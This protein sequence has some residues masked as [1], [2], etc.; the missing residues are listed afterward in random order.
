MLTFASIGGGR[1]G[2]P[3]RDGFFE[4]NCAGGLDTLFAA[5]GGGGAVRC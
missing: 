4:G 3:G 2:G 1:P 5:G